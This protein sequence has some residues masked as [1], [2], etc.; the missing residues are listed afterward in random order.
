MSALAAL[1]PAALPPLRELTE[2]LVDAQGD[3]LAALVVYGSAV[4]GGWVEGVSDI[5]LVVVLRDTDP[6]RLKALA[7]PLL[8]A[9]HKA[10]VE[11]MILKLDNLAAASDVF[12]LL[13]DDIRSRHAL[14]HGV[15]LF[16][17]LTI[18]DAHRR[19][20][21]EQELREARIRMRRIVVDAMGAEESL[22]GPLI[23]KVRQVRSPLHALLSLRG[24][25]CDDGVESVLRE[26]GQLYGLDTA[27]LLR[28]AGDAAAAHAAFRK[29]LDAAIEDVDKLVVAA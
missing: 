6:P 8:L 27:P 19:L 3:N 17:A 23:R 24:V 15:D 9:R 21:I 28:V 25:A 22:V 16:A 26:A 4:R 7:L 14:L 1:P 5:D 10:R 29:L 13:Y 18:S 20:R 12:P 2:A 11:A